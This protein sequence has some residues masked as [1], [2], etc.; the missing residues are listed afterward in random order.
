[1]YKKCNNDVWLLIDDRKGN[2]SQI[3][4]AAKHIKSKNVVEKQIFYNNLA[5]LPNFL[6]SKNIPHIIKRYKRQLKAPWPKLVI[7]CGRRSSTVGLWVKKQSNNYSKY[8]QIMW[9][10]Y[11]HKNI[12][13]IFTPE[14]D[15]V[16]NKKNVINIFSSPNIIDEDL[17]KDSYLKWK[18]N[19]NNFTSPK[20]AVLVG[21]DTK[22]HVLK[23]SHIKILVSYIKSLIKDTKASL[24]ITTSRRTS[25]ECFKTLEEELKNLPIKSMLWGPNKNTTNPYFGILAHA[26]LIIVTGDSISLS[27]EAAATGKPILIFAPKDITIK[28]HK[29][30]HSLLIKNNIAKSIEKFNIK[31]IKNIRYKPINEASRIADIIN[32]KFL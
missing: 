23:S 9:P 20:I 19:F 1:M 25:R 2:S 16:L 17:L 11:P 32:K 15:N 13:L 27:S 22:N 14:H 26:D 31:E 6:L 10:G 7:G 30:F 12:D 29:I 24:L 5:I 18:K 21:G 3:L 8:V 28:K 4:G